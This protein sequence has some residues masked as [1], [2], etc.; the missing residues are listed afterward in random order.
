[1]NWWKG[2]KVKVK[3]NEPMKAYTT[4]KI[5]GPARYFIEPFDAEALKLLLK[6]LKRY[7]IPF[8]VMGAGSNILANDKGVAA[9]VLRLN[10]ASFKKISIRNHCIDAGAAAMLGR[11]IAC[12]QKHGLSGLEFLA[13]IPGTV[14]GALAMNAGV[15]GDSIGDTVEEVRVMDYCGRV[16]TIKKKD[17][18]FGYRKSSLAKYIILSA[19][20]KLSAGNKNEIRNKISRNLR[21]RWSVHDLS[22]PSAGCAFKNPDGI[23]AGRLMDLCGLKGKRIGRACISHKHANFIL[24]M[25][26]ANSSDVLRL[27]NLARDQVKKKFKISLEPEIIIWQ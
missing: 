6:T 12:A 3:L 5:G 7:N 14:G 25:G 21:H 19:R 8:L 9:A 4:F 26:N 18:T 10:A 15:P 11:I 23:S 20:L 13:G 27:M 1:M 24:N 22:R 17:I 2:L 16:K